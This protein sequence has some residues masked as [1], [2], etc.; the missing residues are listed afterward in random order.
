MGNAGFRTPTTQ[1]QSPTK[2]LYF[3]AFPPKHR[4]WD[5]GSPT[6]HFHP[7]ARVHS[8]SSVLGA[9][10]AR[11][12]IRP[13]AQQLK[14]LREPRTFDSSFGM[15]RNL[16]PPGYF[17]FEIGE[18]KTRLS[19]VSFFFA[20]GHWN[21]EGFGPGLPMYNGPRALET[22]RAATRTQFLNP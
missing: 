19:R 7:S 10:Q 14:A 8:A 22:L 16:I 2:I 12:A 21:S 4:F 6:L 3:Q 5:S 11:R 9:E 13:R 15:L 18:P 20:Y 17:S 1:P